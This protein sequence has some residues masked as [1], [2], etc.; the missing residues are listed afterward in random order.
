MN[1]PHCS[2]SIQQKQCVKEWTAKWMPLLMRK[3]RT[4]LIS[5]FI[6]KLVLSLFILLFFFFGI[7]TIRKSQMNKHG[8]IRFFFKKHQM[9]HDCGLRLHQHH[10]VLQP[11]TFLT[12]LLGIVFLCAYCRKKNMWNKTADKV[13]SIFFFVHHESD[14]LQEC[15]AKL[16]SDFG[17]HN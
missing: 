7:P 15:I 5:K 10:I 13:A 1:V 6:T 17:N 12:E 3:E 4:I 14:M 9:H 11:N 2:I 16:C 8:M